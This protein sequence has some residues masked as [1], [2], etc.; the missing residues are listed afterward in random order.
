MSRAEKIELT[1]GC[2]L[3]H[4][5]QILLQQSKH[6]SW[7]GLCLPGGHVEPGESF[8]EAV[9]REMREETGLTVLHPQLCGIKQFPNGEGERYIVLLFRADAFEG[10][11]I[12]SEEGRNDWYPRADLPNLPLVDDLLPQLAVMESDTLT[13]FQQIR[14]DGGWIERQL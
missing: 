9:I 6:K 1:V 8:V 7:Q 12:S 10:E 3:Y 14:A 5:G 2:A 4:E 11:L 13:E